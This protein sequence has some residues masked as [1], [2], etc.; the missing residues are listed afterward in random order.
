MSRSFTEN[1]IR[2]RDIY[3]E[4]YLASKRM[5][6][7]LV[8]LIYDLVVPQLTLSLVK[9]PKLFFGAESGPFY[10]PDLQI[11]DFVEVI[12]R[13]VS[14]F[15]PNTGNQ[16]IEG[17][18]PPF[19]AQM[20]VPGLRFNGSR[21]EGFMEFLGHLPIMPHFYTFRQ[22]DVTYSLPNRLISSIRKISR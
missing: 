9:P 5:A 14:Y 13:P 18:A 16:F 1:V 3:F 21:G 10:R 8:K 17:A 15:Q 2:S 6:H 7:D 19:G 11:G 4:I 12:L 22:G 20:G